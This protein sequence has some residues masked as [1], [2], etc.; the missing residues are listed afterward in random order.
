VRLRAHCAWGGGAPATLDAEL[1]IGHH[2]GA[3]P[4]AS[5]STTPPRNGVRRASAV[6]GASADSALEI[7][8]TP[9]D[10]G[11]A[12]ATKDFVVSVFASDAGSGDAPAATN[13]T[14]TVVAEGRFVSLS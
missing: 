1:H 3:A 4:E 2:D 9:D 6:F 8:V 5:A 11:G 14:A 7:V 13:F 12:S 10:S